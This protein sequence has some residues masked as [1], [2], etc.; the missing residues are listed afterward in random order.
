MRKSDVI[1]PLWLSRGPKYMRHWF[2]RGERLSVCGRSRN[3]GRKA[4]YEGG[5]VCRTCQLAL[6]RAW[7]KYLREWVFQC[8]R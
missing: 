1:E 4:E 7:D 8:S 5:P 6:M 2:L 3:T